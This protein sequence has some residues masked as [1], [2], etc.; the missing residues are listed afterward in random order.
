[1]KRAIAFSLFT[2]FE[3]IFSIM[4]A[5]AYAKDGELTKANLIFDKGNYRDA[6]AI[7]QREF[8]KKAIRGEEESIAIKAI[9]NAS[10][11]FVQLGEEDGSDDFFEMVVAKNKASWRLLRSVAGH[12]NSQSGN[13]YILN[14]Q[15]KRGYA[16]AGGV[17]QLNSKARDRVRAIQ[18][19]L[20][21]L[22][23]A[24][25]AKSI[26][27]SSPEALAL[28]Y[29]DLTQLFISANPHQLSDLE[30][31]PEYQEYEHF[32]S[33]EKP[34]YAPVDKKQQPI[35]FYTP[36]SFESAKSDGERW[37]WVLGEREK[38]GG[39]E[40][41]AAQIEMA[42]F[43]V[44]QFGTQTLAGAFI[45]QMVLSEG[46]KLDEEA[47]TS[48]YAVETLSDEETIARLAT[49]I[50]RFKMPS[51]FNP[52]LILKGLDY[53]SS[54]QHLYALELLAN[55]YENR[56]QFRQA[57][58]Y[59]KKLL[60]IAPGERKRS[61]Q[62]SLSQIVGA[63]GQFEGEYDQAASGEEIELTYR[64][65][66]ATS[67]KLEAYK[68]DAEKLLDDVIQYIKK[69]SDYYNLN[70]QK[71]NVAG[72][73]DHLVEENSFKYIS[74]KSLAWSIELDPAPN[75]FDKL[76]KIKAPLKEGGA[77]LITAQPAAGNTSRVVAWLYDG[78]L[79]SK[80][81]ENGTLFYFADAKSGAPLAD[82]ELE[83]FGY[84]SERDSSN[85]KYKIVTRSYSTRSDRLGQHILKDDFIEDSGHYRWLVIARS[86][87]GRSAYWGFDNL[88]QH[89]FY[90]NEYKNFKAYLI[91]DRPVYRPQD[92]VQFR[93]WL[94]QP[95][96]DA[97]DNKQLYGREISYEIHNPRN[98]KIFEER[99]TLDQDGGFNSKY[100]VT[101]DATLGV[102]RIHI[103]NYG[104]AGDFR[105]EEYKKPE[106]EVK[107]ELP[108][109]EILLG[110]KVKGKISAQY[111]FG[112][113]VTQARIK[114]KIERLTANDFWYPL[115]EWDWLYGNGYWWFANDYDWYPGWSRWGCKRPFR[116]WWSGYFAPSPPELVA[117]AEE[118][119][120]DDGTFEF[121]ID[122]QPA[123]VFFEEKNHRYRVTAQV[124]DKS[125]RMIIGSGDILVASSPFKVYAWL[126][127]GYYTVGDTVVA[128]FSAQ[129]INKE[130]IEGEGE[131]KLF[132]ISYDRYRKPS[133]ELIESWQVRSDESG[134]L[135]HKLI[136]RATGQY[137]VAFYLKDK[138]GRNGEGGYIFSV[139]GNEAR[140]ESSFRFNK[141]EIIPDK[142]EYAPEEKLTLKINSDKKDATVLLF[143]RPSSSNHQKIE[144][145]K[146]EGKSAT[147]T[148]PIYKDDMP[149]FFVEA[150]TIFDGRVYQ[151]VREI[152]VP[153]KK[154]IL[155]LKVSTDK[156]RYKPNQKVALKVNIFNEENQPFQAA[157]SVAAYDKALEYISGGSNVPHISEYFWKW[158]RT[159]YQYNR[160]SLKNYLEQVMLK[161]EI[162]MRELGVLGGLNKSDEISS[163]R[164]GDSG[165]PAS[166]GL[167]VSSS[168]LK[169]SQTSGERSEGV[170]FEG[171]AQG[172]GKKS[173]AASQP[174]GDSQAKPYVASKLRSDFIDTAYWN[175]FIEGSIK[176][177]ENL[178]FNLPDNLTTW[179]IRAWAVASQ[180]EVGEISDE[181]VVTKDLL[182]RLQLPRFSVTGDE[183]TISANLHNYLK[184]KKKVRARIEISGAEVEVLDPHTKEL[185]ILAAGEARVD[186]RVKIKGAGEAKV[187]V[188]AE[189]DEESD[190]VEL[191]LP[192]LVKGILK[193]EAWSGVVEKEKESFTFKVPK[194]RIATESRFILQYSPTL[195]GA[196][197]DAL[198]YLIEY[199][200]GCTEQTLN[201]FLPT[202]IA[203]SLLKDLG[204]NLE[205]IK[206]KRANLNPQELGDAPQRSN[207][208]DKFPSSE[209]VFDSEKVSELVKTGV[210]K[211]ASMQLSDGGWGWLSGDGEKSSPHTTVLVVRGLL[212]AK[213]LKIDVPEDVLA[214]GIDWLFHYRAIQ[215][216]LI[217]NHQNKVEPQKSRADDL[218][219]FIELVLTEA[220]KGSK[221][222]REYLYRDRSQLA[223]YGKALLGLVLNADDEKQKLQTVLQNLSQ[224][225]VEESENQSAYLKSA[226]GN[227]WWHWY[228]SE[229]EAHAF[230]LKLLVKQDVNSRLAPK[231]IKYLL[232]NRRNSNYWNSTRDTALLIE[233]FAEYLKATKELNSELEVEILIDGKKTKELKINKDNLFAFD[234]NLV[235]DGDNISHG[236]HKVE[237]VKK[238]EGKL[239]FNAYLDNFTLEEPIK[240]AGLEIKVKRTFYKFSKLT[241]NL[242][243]IG[244]RGE[245]I[246]INQERYK[247]APLLDDAQLNSGD[248]I[249][250]EL[251]LESKNDYEYLLF[252]DFK[253]A[254]LEALEVRS[255][256]DGNPLGAYVEYRDQKVSF[257]VT[258]L[259]RGK[260][261]LSYRL[262]AETPGRFT[263]LPAIAQAMYAPELRA[264]S[265]SEKIKV[266]S[267][268]KAELQLGQ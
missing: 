98:E 42:K 15:F 75:H 23:V 158:K 166:A 157:L 242:D 264:N 251:E 65:R 263:A 85:D 167:E 204:I 186:W 105:V 219:A 216:G 154:K 144:I 84:K 13:G 175:P 173:Q 80:P 229:Y 122:T 130:G 86:K 213:K 259:P 227:Y 172:G 150:L 226:G 17:K 211:L 220:E 207:K 142:R 125:R 71:I 268:G 248:L 222:M 91:S 129:N 72:L 109:E 63:W 189:S 171:N 156:K 68:I 93:V 9:G 110:E 78:A 113:A 180:S 112:A 8:A 121:E 232:N 29:R 11:A 53:P 238:G 88:W 107:V 56:R 61:Y 234:N 143:I 169:R 134:Q 183:V 192:L 10:A 58:S 74:K 217:K 193:R 145:V 52:I 179:K 185:E 66:N 246:K 203:S 188:Y 208:W 102:Y 99:I 202:V 40:R 79:V 244:Q 127:R 153:P 5:T 44:T 133:E 21:A 37:R 46:K 205:E 49:G 200:Y 170:F 118:N 177:E 116:E 250:V 260:R 174:G 267:S 28:I 26:Y 81:V 199:P 33:W 43:L 108:K 159:Y 62:E 184:D 32:Y 25:Q 165:K 101:K 221:E 39:G 209:A 190:A 55:I 140:D 36:T 123:K 18:L 2:I 64:F 178:S 196:I 176:G 243:A 3:A 231:I 197:L 266:V 215:I 249:E 223:L 103:V 214:R 31:L 254:G 82:A 218:D 111:Y 236:E 141:L 201:R 89:Q 54:A 92:N 70:Y 34:R 146:L 148:I 24:E 151:E 240:A 187:K 128:N 90:G 60:E 115:G 131:L 164:L 182:V 27:Q 87:D 104:Y 194:E 50:K 96:Y 35:F 262:R 230:Y 191:K 126:D 67:V 69:Q 235:L 20:E 139:Y 245:V 4:T 45:P 137:R 210:S 97:P 241:A 94:R 57:A 16:R 136:A 255:G 195:A 206:N 252:E 258:H 83:F 73:R 257:F 19:L 95:S 256:Y 30:T 233:A 265:N 228:G 225:V 7:Y 51:E 76:V 1:M 160:T 6:L 48:I 120:G 253:A 149:N 181:I 224:Y 162:Y 147:F 132:K 117:E 119:I 12:Y 198:P 161:N 163:F 135:S 237:I 59:W 114:Y 124:T 38:L 168:I 41:D 77:Y 247:R 138:K 14:G 261:N 22:K 152:A 47:A 100:R 106:F 155:K 239:Y 212:L